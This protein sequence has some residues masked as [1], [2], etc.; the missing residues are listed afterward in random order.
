MK[1]EENPAL[2]DKKLL[3]ETYKQ[4]GDIKRILKCHNEAEEYYLSAKR[5]FDDHE[6]LLRESK[7]MKLAIV[8]IDDNLTALCLLKK[9]NTGAKSHLNHSIPFLESLFAAEQPLKLAL[10]YMTLG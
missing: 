5:I 7:E 8:A 10:P 4:I 2:E 9:N 6:L 1:E 3:I